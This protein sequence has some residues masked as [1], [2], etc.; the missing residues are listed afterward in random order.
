MGAELPAKREETAWPALDREPGG[1]S[2][3]AFNKRCELCELPREHAADAAA[4]KHYER[5]RVMRQGVPS[6]RRVG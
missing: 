3:H 2:C 5:L 4:N 1:A 6:Y